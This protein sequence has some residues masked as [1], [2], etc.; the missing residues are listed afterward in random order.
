VSRVSTRGS[1]TAPQ[2]F[3]PTATG[4]TVSIADP[5]AGLVLYEAVIPGSSLEELVAG[6]IYRIAARPIAAPGRVSMRLIVL[7]GTAR[8]N[9]RAVAGDLTPFLPL[10]RLA[11]VVRIGSNNCAQEGDLV[12][13]ATSSTALCN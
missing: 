1:F 5:V 6:R 7:D 11:V 10:S 2:S 9:I 13:H 4:F 3:D 12:C 8:L